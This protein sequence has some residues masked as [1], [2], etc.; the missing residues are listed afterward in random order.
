MDMTHQ[1]SNS[2][3]R[4]VLRSSAV[5]SV[6]SEATRVYQSWK[7]RLIDFIQ[8]L[9][10]NLWDAEKKIWRDN[11]MLV[12]SDLLVQTKQVSHSKDLSSPVTMIV[13]CFPIWALTSVK[14]EGPWNICVVI[15]ESTLSPPPHLRTC[16]PPILTPNVQIAS[17]FMQVTESCFVGN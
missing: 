11:L 17:T 5:S 6:T 8:K 10:P 2:G 13:L 15:T 7:S 9:I 16:I 12:T 4:I 14:R 1:C 3:N